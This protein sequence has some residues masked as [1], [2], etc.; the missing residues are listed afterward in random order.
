MV[1]IE[2]K[3]G[4]QKNLIPDHVNLAAE[5]ASLDTRLKN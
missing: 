3:M 1:Q 2:N 5:T 4:L